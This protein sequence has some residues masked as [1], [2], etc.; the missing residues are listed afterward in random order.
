MS[1]VSRLSLTLLT[2]LLAP[3]VTLPSGPVA[4]NLS[5]SCVGRNTR[6]L[7]GEYVNFV[8]QRWKKLTKQHW[9]N[10]EPE[11]LAPKIC[12][13]KLA[14]MS[15][16]PKIGKKTLKNCVKKSKNYHTCEKLAHAARPLQPPFSISVVWLVWTLQ[17]D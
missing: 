8:W 1:H 5:W 13:Q 7:V 15:K 4:A 10:F 16:M 14:K 2:V 6:Q 3:I 17:E 12:A 11:K 9:Q